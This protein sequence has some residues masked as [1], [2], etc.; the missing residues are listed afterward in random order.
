MAQVRG[1]VAPLLFVVL[2]AAF[3]AG[4]WGAYRAAFP[5]QGLHRASGVYE[6]RLSDLMISVRHERIPG[7]MDEM[8]SMV[9]MAESRELIDRAQLKPGDRVRLTVRTTAER[10]LL[11]DIQ[12]IQ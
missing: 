8:K 12:K 5:G 11:V 2:L 7:V 1:W 3:A 6:N 10:L 9:F 4:I